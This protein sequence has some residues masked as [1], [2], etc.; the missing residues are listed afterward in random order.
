MLVTLTNGAPLGPFWATYFNNATD[1]RAAGLA[2][3]DDAVRRDHRD[4][5][6]L[7]GHDRQRRPRGRRPRGQP[8]GGDRVHRASARSTTSSPRRCCPRTPSCRWSD[9][10]ARPRPAPHRD[11]PHDAGFFGRIMRRRLHRPRAAA[12]SARRCARPGILITGSVLIVLALVFILGLQCGI[13]G[14]YGAKAVG[15]Q[16]VGGRVHRAVQPARGHPLRV[17]LHDG[18]EGRHR[19]GRRAR[20]DADLRR[21]RRARGDGLRLGRCTCAPRGCSAC[22]SCCRSS[23]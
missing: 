11:R 3:Q 13:E 10:R 23:T 17:R 5:L 22:G 8:G 9:E 6:L 4:R 16:S 14:A 1:R 20:L 7:Q 15:A 21:D 2:A 18:R 19:H 12:S